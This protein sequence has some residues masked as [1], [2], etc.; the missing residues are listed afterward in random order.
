MKNKT[1]RE[2]NETDWD[3]IVFF[4]YMSEYLKNPYLRKEVMPTTYRLKK[5][6]RWP[7]AGWPGEAICIGYPWWRHQCSHGSTMLVFIVCLLFF[8]WKRPLVLC[9]VFMP[10]GFARLYSLIVNV[11][12]QGFFFFPPL[13][14][15]QWYHCDYKEV[16][17][18]DNRCKLATVAIP[19]P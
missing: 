2:Q 6:M 1:L 5:V 13:L 4:F 15:G 18:P 9:I 12:L 14:W 19:V 7:W 3:L 11:L 17:Q 16:N 10:K 8:F